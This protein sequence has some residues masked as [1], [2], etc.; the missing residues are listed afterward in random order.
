TLDILASGIREEQRQFSQELRFASAD[1]GPFE[2]VVGLYYFNQDLETQAR[3][4]AG[5]DLGVYPYDVEG[6]IFADVD[7]DSYAAFAHGTYRLSDTLSLTGGLRYTREEKTVLHSQQGDPL[8]LLLPNIA[9]RSISMSEENLS[10]TI[11]LNYEPNDDLFLYATFAQGYKSGGFNVFSISPTDD[12]E[13]EPEHV[14]NY[15]I[16]AK[17]EFFDRRL[18]IDVS[19]YYLD[20][21]N[22]QASQLLLINNLAVFQTSNA[23]RARSVGAEISVMARPTAELTLAATYGYNEATFPSYPNATSTGADYTGH[24]LPRAPQNNASFSAQYERPLFGDVSLFARGELSHRSKIFFAADNIH[25]EDPVTL[26]NARL[27]LQSSDGWGVYLWGRNL[28]DVDYA[29]YREAGAIVP[30]Q[31]IESL[32]A[33]QTFGLEVRGRF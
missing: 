19:A 12:A 28:T 26:F 25:S 4:I 21:R 10:P 22:L 6:S 31:V 11:G 20:Y 14:N 29:I 32:A 23:A 16:G 5:V 3:L 18:Q 33:P 24:T 30:G 15:E 2:Y 13:Y 9:P 17:S 7:T 27:G 8:Q 1:H